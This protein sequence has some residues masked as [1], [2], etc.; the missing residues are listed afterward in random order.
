[1]KSI[2]EGEYLCNHHWVKLTYEGFDGKWLSEKL[3]R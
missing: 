3:S 2:E 1:M